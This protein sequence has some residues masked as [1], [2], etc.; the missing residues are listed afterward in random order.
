M[1]V[2]LS[3]DIMIISIVMITTPVIYVFDMEYI[4]LISTYHQNAWGIPSTIKIVFEDTFNLFL[5]AC[6]IGQVL[7][8]S[9]S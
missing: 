6:L 1:L 4:L 2:V 3:N 7:T 8:D 9:A 5:M